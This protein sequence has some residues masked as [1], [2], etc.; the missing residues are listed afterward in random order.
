VEFRV[1]GRLEVVGGEGPIVLRGVKRRALVGLLLVERGRV[2]STDRV[3]RHVWDDDPDSVARVKSAIHELRRLFGA[4]GDRLMTATGGYALQV[5]AGELD[6]AVFEEM[7]AQAADTGDRRR[8]AVGL[9]SEALAQW[10]GD[11]FEEFADADWAIGEASRLDT[12]RLRAL[13]ALVDAELEVGEH[14]QV[15]ARLEALVVDHPLREHFWAQ[16]MVALYRCGRQAEAL[17]A[18]QRVRVL[19]ADELGISPSPALVELERRVLAQDPTLAW[20]PPQSDAPQPNNPDAAA[21]PAGTVTSLLSDVELRADL[22]ESPGSDRSP[23]LQGVP[24]RVLQRHPDLMTERTS[25]A[26]D[27]HASVRTVA[28]LF[29]D[30]VGS[31]PLIEA[32]GDRYPNLLLRHR[33]LLATAFAGHGGSLSS[34]EGDGCLALFPSATA[35]ISAAVDGQRALG[36]ERWP[37]G[38][39]VRV[40]M[41]VHIGDVLVA[42]GEPIG[43]AV[44]HAA[45]MLACGGP[46]QVLVSADA[47]A[48]A[49]PMRAGIGLEDAGTHRLP[50][51]SR[52]VTL[53]QVAAEGLTIAERLTVS[54]ETDG[55]IGR[56]SDIVDVT[57]TLARRRLVTITG[58]GG[59][60][61][62][63]LGQAVLERWRRHAGREAVRWVDLANLSDASLVPTAVGAELGVDSVGNDPLVALVQA[64]DGRG[65]LIVLDNCEHVVDGVLPLIEAVDRRCPDVKV[66]ATSRVK[67]GV[68]NEIEHQLG[69]LAVPPEQRHVD[70]PA[71]SIAGYP[72]VELFLARAAAVRPG[73]RLT[74]GNVRQVAELSRR[75]DG[76]PLAIE[77]A[78][79]RL[80]VLS[81][82]QLVARL[83][84]LDVLKDQDSR[85]ARQRTMRATIDWSYDLL[86]PNEQA[87]FRRISVFTGGFTL[88]AAE[89]VLRG[90]GV[91][92]EDTT[93]LIERLLAHGLV[94]A[95]LESE[96]FRFRML[97]P[98][99]QYAASRLAGETEAVLVHRAHAAWAV[100][101]AEIAEREFFT[102]Q[103]AWTSVLQHEQHNIRAALLGALGRGEE[104]TALRIVAA[105]GYAW[106]TMGQPDGRSLVDRALEAAGD[107]DD[108]RLRARALLASGL[109]A[110]D[111]TDYAAARLQ[112]EQA[113]TL[114]ELCGSRRGQ[115]WTYV[116][117][118]RDQDAYSENARREMLERA[119]QLFRDTGDQRGVAMSLALAADIWLRAGDTRGG[120][121]HGEEAFAVA[122][123]A[124]ITQVVGEALRVLGWAAFDDDDLS[125]A[126][127]LWREAADIHRSGGD[128][129]QESIVEGL[130]GQAAAVMGDRRSALEHFAR[131]ASLGAHINPHLFA[132]LLQSLVPF[133]WRLG[134]REE[135]A[136]LLGAYDALRP[137]G[138]RASSPT[139]GFYH[140][141]PRTIWAGTTQMREVAE[142]VANSD[143]EA[144]RRL[145]TQLTFIDA[146]A[147]A[148]RVIAEERAKLGFEAL[149]D[150][151]RLSS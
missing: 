142:Q 151:K 23:E 110:Q 118:S 96:V 32:A 99:R 121:R 58:P 85:D 126:R 59:S 150:H 87:T 43:L 105:L 61:K 149:P 55:L 11:A 90:R 134:R 94:V 62:T 7:V 24:L 39:I 120:R 14:A 1:L 144:A 6:A 80:R 108:D 15:V 137:G 31:T 128:R 107:V 57:D 111:E 135:A 2:V 52:P 29:S 139:R 109:L 130:A 106:F 141:R 103:P 27:E 18:Y 65:M 89:K 75:L 123:A 21:Q 19:L 51:L 97:E 26:A 70:D 81:L 78:A 101:V 148:T 100:T 125:E 60:G 20:T 44:H 5:R 143:L 42:G 117:L 17:R 77:L 112:L 131:A 68:R 35:A 30:V 46:G 41:V 25:A 72:S 16:L 76:L 10:R 69:P 45:R 127:R 91:A 4:D 124:G 74:P 3:V 22:A 40:R 119:L 114:F 12:M 132:V 33:E 92:A 145:G 79:A 122:S 9:L 48:S 98:V 116:V 115:A 56:D 54:S 86:D 82:D 147:F 73:F 50:D 104:V 28:I 8:R 37:A 64:L 129:W 83:D 63:R 138:G 102:D 67:L 113:L 136:Q 34:W 95:D 38:L 84:D 47:A 140:D 49:N 13:E 133:L 88:D 53:F 71:L 93:D 36:E 66:L 146:S